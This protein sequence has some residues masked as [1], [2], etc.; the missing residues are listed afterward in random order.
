MHHIRQDTRR[1]GTN[2]L[3]ADTPINTAGPRKKEIIDE[4]TVA[5]PAACERKNQWTPEAL[6]YV[7]ELNGD[8]PP[9]EQITDVPNKLIT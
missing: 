4:S 8:N 6:T 9:R 5:P 3:S 1:L 7:R 2:T